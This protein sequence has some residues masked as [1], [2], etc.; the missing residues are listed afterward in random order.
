MKGAGGTTGGFGGFFLGLV[1]LCGGTYLLLNSIAV[2]SSFGWGSRLYGV[3]FG[4]VGVTGGMLLIPFVIGIGLL[5]YNA[6][7]VLGW[8]L[9]GGALVALVF[10][11]LASVSFRMQ[12]M[13]A[14]ELL[15]ILVLAVGGL[16]LFLRSLRPLSTTL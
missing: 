5:F 13:T 15:A 9:A 3:S 14:F 8:L 12:G 4:G 16:G 7:N 2:A 10:G 11:V 6:R 1:M